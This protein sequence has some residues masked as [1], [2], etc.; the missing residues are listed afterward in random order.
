MIF[1]IVAAVF[2]L[3][4]I[5]ALAT[6]LIK[7]ELGR[8]S[9]VFVMAGGIANCIDR[10]LYGYVQDMFRFDFKVLG[11]DFPIFNVADVF[12]TV[13]SILFILYIIF[14]GGKSR[15][16]DEDELDEDEEVFAE[17][18]EDEEDDVPARRPAK[19]KA[20]KE[21]KKAAKRAEP[22]DDEDEDE[23]VRPAR[24]KKSAEKR[25]QPRYEQEYEQFKAERA[26]R[27]Q[28]EPAA[29]VTPEIDPNDPFAEW[30]R[31]NAAVRPAARTASDAGAHEAK[32]ARA[33]A[34]KKSAAEEDEFDLE[35][36]LREY[37]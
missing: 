9:A 27:G 14:G 30:E 10:L 37:E 24:P 7:G 5:I 6:R 19:K 18:D 26:A 20:K 23:D 13:F 1:V 25:R 12:I 4:V 35:S 33:A 17:D 11:F 28:T 32:P 29:R 15:D 34:P 2:A 31:A 36:I 3:F 21:T 22:E 8:W 16:E